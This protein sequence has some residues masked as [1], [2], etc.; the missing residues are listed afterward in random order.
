[1]FNIVFK[2]NKKD[3]HK[4]TFLYFYNQTQ[5]LPQNR[6]QKLLKLMIENLKKW[7]KTI[8]YLQLKGVRLM[9]R[10]ML[11]PLPLK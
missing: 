10:N 4:L 7:K 8:R 3:K 6:V 11:R 9:M 2:L 1:M 5:R